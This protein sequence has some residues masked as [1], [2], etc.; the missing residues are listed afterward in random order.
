VYLFEPTTNANILVLDDAS[1]PAFMIWKAANV[2]SVDHHG[3]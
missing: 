3:P 2:D 1:K